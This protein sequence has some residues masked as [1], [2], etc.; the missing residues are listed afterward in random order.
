MLSGIL[1]FKPQTTLTLKNLNKNK[2]FR[3]NHPVCSA[4]S[5]KIFIFF[6]FIKNKFYYLLREQPP[7]PR[8]E[9]FRFQETFG[10]PFSPSVKAT[11]CHLPLRGRLY[12]TSKNTLP[13]PKNY[14]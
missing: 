5:K 9:N 2:I 11:P 13:P 4:Q 3:R 6:T 12:D 7:L 1:L 8:G 10:L 14:A